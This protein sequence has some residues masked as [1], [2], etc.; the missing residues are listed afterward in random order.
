MTPDPE[1][2]A[3]V[4]GSL[5]ER[6]QRYVLACSEEPRAAAFAAY[7]AMPGQFK[8]GSA[9]ARFAKSRPDL[10]DRPGMSNDHC[11]L[12]V[13]TPLG[14]AVRDYINGDKL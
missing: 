2:V 13:L 9:F 10:F 14:L 6:H 4:A 1:L 12:Y 11:W 3:E 5:S 8:T 7:D